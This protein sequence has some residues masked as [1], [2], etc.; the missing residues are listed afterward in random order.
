MVLAEAR[1]VVRRAL[2]RARGKMSSG[3]WTCMMMMMIMI[4]Q[5]FIQ[6]VASNNLHLL[7]SFYIGRSYLVYVMRCIVNMKTL[8]RQ[9]ML[10]VWLTFG[11]SKLVQSL[12]GSLPSRLSCVLTYDASKALALVDSVSLSLPKEPIHNGASSSRTVP[13]ASAQL[14]TLRRR[15]SRLINLGVIRGR[16]TKVSVNAIKVGN[17]KTVRK[18][19]NQPIL[20]AKTKRTMAQIMKSSK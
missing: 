13:S 7:S 10:K 14:K 2:R 17:A 6:Y 11:I 15:V 9:S 12:E 19:E 4:V 8:I 5:I 1:K 3:D 18:S 16:F 20:R